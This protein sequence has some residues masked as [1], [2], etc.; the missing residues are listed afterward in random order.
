MELERVSFGEH[1]MAIG[2][3]EGGGEVSRVE[4]RVALIA[5]RELPDLVDP[6]E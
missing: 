2:A 6:T 4:D 1:I 3:R 5:P